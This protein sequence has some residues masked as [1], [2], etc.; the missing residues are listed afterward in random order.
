MN[1]LNLLYVAIDAIAIT[2]VVLLGLRLI[3]QTSN[4][5]LVV[6][7]AWI[8]LGIVSNVITSRD[9]YGVLIDMGYRLDLGQLHP[10]FNL[11][12]NS[13]AGA[14]MLASHI[15]FRDGKQ[16]PRTLLIL[17]IAQIFLEEP[18]AWI[19]GT[20]WHDV[21]ETVLYE[22][23]PAVLQ[24]SFLGIAL[25]WI[26]SNREDDLIPSRQKARWLVL[27]LFTAQA[28]LSLLV[29]RIAF[30]FRW[31]P[32]EW[33]YPIHVLVV[34][35]GIPLNGVLL[36][37]AFSPNAALVLG[38]KRKVA[39][40][41][42]STARIMQDEADAK[43]IRKALEEEQIYR[44][45]GLSVRALAEHLSIPEYRLRIL[46]HDHLGFRN[47]NALLH[48]YRVEEV[49][50]ALEDPQL[51]TVPVLTLALTAGYQSINPFNRAFRESHGKTPTEYRRLKQH[52]VDS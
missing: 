28:G 51:N 19:L 52:Q 49:C 8:T 2:L 47:F 30:G 7:F 35:L 12:R 22:A 39:N 36:F 15:I 18:L 5:Q 24:T 11:L 25:Y 33:Q 45:P 46:V 42:E 44:T 10:L 40:A 43:K 3:S 14:V 31:I 23:I 9:D 27:G 41:E 17:W 38:E 34:S 13:T 50:Q 1:D 16:A 20:G 26:G 6:L 37:A 4:R 29:E 32:F 48:H 21:I